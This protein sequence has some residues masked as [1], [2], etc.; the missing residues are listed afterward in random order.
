MAETTTYVENLYSDTLR[1][2]S[3]YFNDA[4]YEKRNLEQKDTT[5]NAL[6][7]F[8]QN[9]VV[10][11]ADSTF[12]VFRSFTYGEMMISFLLLMILMTIVFKWLWEV[13]RS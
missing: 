4:F 8:F 1:A 12:Q 2:L 13:L 3:N 9:Y 5:L 11:T 10:E 7:E 6:N